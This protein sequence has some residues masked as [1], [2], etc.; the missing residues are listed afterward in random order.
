VVVAQQFVEHVLPPVEV[1][2]GGDSG[3]RMAEEVGRG[4]GGQGDFKL[5]VV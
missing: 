3:R 2:L 1:G 4:V 5:I